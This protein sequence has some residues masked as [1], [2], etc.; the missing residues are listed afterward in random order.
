MDK[1][2]VIRFLLGYSFVKG[3]D[4]EISLLKSYGGDMNEFYRSVRNYLGIMKVFSN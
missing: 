1:V 2:Y 4:V 3:K